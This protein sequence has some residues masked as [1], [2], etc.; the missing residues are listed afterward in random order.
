MENTLKSSIALQR[1]EAGIM[2]RRM[3]G[4]GSMDD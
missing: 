4:G 1:E 2:D 3:V